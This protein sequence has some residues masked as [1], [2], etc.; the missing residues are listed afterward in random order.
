MAG[1]YEY[2]DKNSDLIMIGNFVDQLR[3]NRPTFLMKGPY[4]MKFK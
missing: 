3:N 4:S 1:F 2:G